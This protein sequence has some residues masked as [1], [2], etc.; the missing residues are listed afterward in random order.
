MEKSKAFEKMKEELNKLNFSKPG[1]SFGDYSDGWNAAVDTLGEIIDRFDRRLR[2]EG[3]KMKIPKNS[4][5]IYDKAHGN[6]CGYLSKRG[7]YFPYVQVVL[8]S[9]SLFTCRDCGGAFER[10]GS[11][12][13][14]SH[15]GF[16]FDCKEVKA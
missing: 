6:L 13:P 3:G 16:C 15:D 5:P 7:N 10:E 2:K 11:T 8:G 4:T 14:I 9:F 12:M 1:L